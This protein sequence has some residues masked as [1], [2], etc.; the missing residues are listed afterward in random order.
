MKYPRGGQ[1]FVSGDLM[2]MFKSFSMVEHPKNDLL[3]NANIYFGRKKRE[4]LICDLK[5][6]FNTIIDELDEQFPKFQKLL[7]EKVFTIKI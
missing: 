4:D 1:S 7:I 3:R 5:K 2:K 6:F